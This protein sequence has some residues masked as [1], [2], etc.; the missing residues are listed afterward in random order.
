MDPSLNLTV[1]PDPSC[2][3][4]IRVLAVAFMP[5]CDKLLVISSDAYFAEDPAGI[6]NAF[7]LGNFIFQSLVGLNG[8]KVVPGIIWDEEP[9]PPTESVWS[10]L[11]LFLSI[12]IP[13]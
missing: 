8:N 5:V 4:S 12:C 1:P 3:N 2:H 13:R 10:G 6:F 9:S 11:I 7:E